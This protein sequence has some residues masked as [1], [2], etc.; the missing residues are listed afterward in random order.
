MSM[1]NEAFK[2]IHSVFVLCDDS[3]SMKEG[4][5]KLVSGQRCS[6]LD[7]QS[8]T[9]EN[10]VRVVQKDGVPTTFKFLNGDVEYQSDNLEGIKAANYV[11]GGTPLCSNITNYI[12][13]VTTML[14]ELR[15]SDKKMVLVII[16]DGEATDGNLLSAMQPL[17]DLPV[18]VV[19][20]LVTDSSIIVS[21]W[22][23]IDDNLN[24]DF[25]TI[26]DFQSE[27]KEIHIKNPWL[28]YTF[29]FHILRILGAFSPAVFH[30]LDIT[31]GNLIDYL[32]ERPL[33]L[34]EIICFSVFYLGGTIKDHPTDLAG[35][36]SYFNKYE[37]N[38]KVF[39]LFKNR[40]QRIVLPNKIWKYYS[41]I[42]I[43]FMSSIFPSYYR[44]SIEKT[45]L[46]NN[47]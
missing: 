34:K 16:T 8:E 7:E 10:I 35:L 19:L 47:R 1:N 27:S 30:D 3:G 6:R 38:I 43:G 11:K 29:D 15:E 25:D 14:P 42:P 28:S 13:K 45:W 21:Y 18:R 4:D 26:D 32:D 20:R 31:C 24:I 36:C 46:A 33:T 5:G 44:H 23:Y 2:Q 40:Q 39:S 37:S 17:K 22:N 12:S 41:P 9:I